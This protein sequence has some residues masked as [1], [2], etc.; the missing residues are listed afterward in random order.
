MGLITVHFHNMAIA[1]LVPLIAFVVI[2]IYSFYG[3]HVRE[4]VGG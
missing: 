4:A 2:A 1:Y 3:S